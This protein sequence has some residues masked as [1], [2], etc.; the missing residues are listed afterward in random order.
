MGNNLGAGSCCSNTA[1]LPDDTDNLNES[2]EAELIKKL[3][4]GCSIYIVFADGSRLP[5][6]IN[7]DLQRDSIYLTVEGQRR[8]IK[9]DTIKELFSPD[10][11]GISESELKLLKN[12]N[13][14][15]FKLSTTHKAILLQFQNKQDR[16]AFHYF[17]EQVINEN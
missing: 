12:D 17:L 9:L 10:S 14:V 13:I 15:A 5:C 7:Y 1:K 6:C 3:V 16:D 4:N 11:I 8:I 2:Q